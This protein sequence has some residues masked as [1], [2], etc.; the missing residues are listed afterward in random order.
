MIKKCKYAYAEKP[1]FFQLIYLYCFAFNSIYN[2]ASFYVDFRLPRLVMLALLAAYI[3]GTDPHSSLQPPAQ[4]IHYH[5]LFAIIRFMS[6]S[7]V[8]ANFCVLI[9]T[10]RVISNMARLIF[11]W[12]T[13]RMNYCVRV[14]YL[15]VVDHNRTGTVA[16]LS[17]PMVI[18]LNERISLQS[19]S[20]LEESPPPFTA[21]LFLFFHILFRWFCLQQY[22]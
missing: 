8:T 6:V 10:L 15:S 3:S 11:L 17:Q 9:L 1:K 18:G 5:F 7:F 21:T 13:C 12:A 14:G 4:F 20:I 16:D 2:S 22:Q 19:K